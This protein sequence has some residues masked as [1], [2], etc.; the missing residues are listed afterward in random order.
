MVTQ[1]LVDSPERIERRYAQRRKFTGKIE[2]EW[3]SA[4]LVGTVQ[5]IGPQGLFIDLNP[6]LWLGATFLA[7]LFLQP[8]LL[9]NCK[10]KR[11]DP[12]KG[13]GVTF[14]VPEESGKVQLEALLA[15]LPSL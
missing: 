7:R 2:I 1:P 13:I 3:G 15:A 9:L 14:D 5:N 8:V 12:G 6:E 10:V 11:V 4:T